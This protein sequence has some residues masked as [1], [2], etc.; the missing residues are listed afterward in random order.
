M[1][2]SFSAP[3]TFGTRGCRLGCQAGDSRRKN[4]TTAAI[5][6]ITA[7]I[8]RCV[9][10]KP[11]DRA[12]RGVKNADTAVPIMPMPKTPLAKPRRAGSYQALE[13]GMPT[14]KIVPATPR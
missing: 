5:P 8:S 4:Q 6:T 3:I 1:I 12:S 10:K 2:A 9:W 7:A 14:A 11:I 13:N